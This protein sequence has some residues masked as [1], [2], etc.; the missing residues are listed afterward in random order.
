MLSGSLTLVQYFVG[1][2]RY[3]VCRQHQFKR[4]YQRKDTREPSSVWCLVALD[5]K[6][7]STGIVLQ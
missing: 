6:L 4:Q 1:N 3:V 5:W 2:D 7:G